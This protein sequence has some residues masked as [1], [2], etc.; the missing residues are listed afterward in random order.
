MFLRRLPVPVAPFPNETLGSYIARMAVANHLKPATLAKH[1][2]RP[3]TPG[4]Y[5]D[6]DRLVVVS[7]WPLDSLQRSLPE[8]AGERQG[9]EPLR[10]RRYKDA[11]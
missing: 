9:R 10:P 2:H 7:G 11:S 4:L 5:P 1:L 6:L 3:H 8:L